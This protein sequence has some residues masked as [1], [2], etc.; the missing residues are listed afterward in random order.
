MFVQ[1]KAWPLREELSWSGA[2]GLRSE[3]PLISQKRRKG[4]RSRC[5]EM[6]LT[7]RICS[8]QSEVGSLFSR[9]VFATAGAL[10]CMSIL[11]SRGRR[12]SLPHKSGD[13]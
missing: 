6:M 13:T 3:D 9:G 2:V 7:A 10:S 11:W 1:V 8:V 4:K 12:T 5:H